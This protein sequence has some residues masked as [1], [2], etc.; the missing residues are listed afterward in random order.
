VDLFT[1]ITGTDQDPE[2]ERL[3]KVARKALREK[4]VEADMGII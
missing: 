3:V 2:I 1:N 4:F